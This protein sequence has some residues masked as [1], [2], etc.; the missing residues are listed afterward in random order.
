LI[1]ETKE[2]RLRILMMRTFA[3]R[4]AED[5]YKIKIKLEKANKCVN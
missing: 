4:G 5:P 3:R 1:P 2:Y